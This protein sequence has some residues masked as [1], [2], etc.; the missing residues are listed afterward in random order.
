[1]QRFGAK[2]QLQMWMCC[3]LHR[4]SLLVYLLYASLHWMTKGL[5]KCSSLSFLVSDS[6]MKF[7]EACSCELFIW[8]PLWV[9]VN[10][11][12]SHWTKLKRTFLGAKVLLGWHTSCQIIISEFIFLPKHYTISMLSVHLKVITWLFKIAV[13]VGLDVAIHLYT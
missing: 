10:S 7:A 8:K 6:T 11:E 3:F 4:L 9:R 1:M 2:K 13:K 12:C 5:K